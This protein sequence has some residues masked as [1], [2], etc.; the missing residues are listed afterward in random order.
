MDADEEIGRLM[1][2]EPDSKPKS[3]MMSEHRNAVTIRQKGTSTLPGPRLS[4]NRTQRNLADRCAAPPGPPPGPRV[5]YCGC[6]DIGTCGDRSKPSG[7]P[8]HQGRGEGRSGK[9]ATWGRISAWGRG[10]G[11]GVL[12]NQSPRVH[13]SW[14]LRAPIPSANVTHRINRGTPPHSYPSHPHPGDA[15]R[16]LN[17]NTALVR[18]RSVLQRSFHSFLQLNHVPY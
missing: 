9:R 12:L 14:N 3:K 11:L 6:F 7:G 4:A 16:T 15:K 8:Y 13:P 18:L 1:H 2:R 5:T 17:L 10:M